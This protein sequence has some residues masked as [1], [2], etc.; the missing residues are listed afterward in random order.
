MKFI[1][2]AFAILAIS[3]LYYC[4]KKEI[5]QPEDSISGAISSNA[6]VPDLPV[7]NFTPDSAR[8]ESGT[9]SKA[10][11]VALTSVAPPRTTPV[12]VAACGSTSWGNSTTKAYYFTYVYDTLDAGA[13]VEG[14]SI[15][16]NLDAVTTPNR[17]SIIDAVTNQLVAASPW[18]GYAIYSGPWGSSVNLRYG[19][20]TFPR[21]TSRYYLVKVETQ[22]KLPGTYNDD[23]LIT[24]GGCTAPT[25]TTRTYAGVTITY[26]SGSGTLK[27]NTGANLATVLDRLDTDYETY[28]T[29]YENQYPS[30]TPDQLDYQ[31]SISNFNE[32]QPIETFEALFPGF[33]SKRKQLVNLETNYLNTATTLSETTDPDSLDL[34]SDVASNAIVNV[35]NKFI[36]GTTTYEY[37]KDGLYADGVKQQA[38]NPSE[39]SSPAALS[40][41]PSFTTFALCNICD[42]CRNW[43]RKSAWSSEYTDDKGRIW[44]F[45][46]VL[47][48]RG[49]YPDGRGYV[50][51]TIKARRKVGTKWKRKRA[52]CWMQM[53]GTIWTNKCIQPTPI[54]S[55]VFQTNRARNNYRKKYAPVGS[56]FFRTKKTKLSA[57]FQIGP[58]GVSNWF[59]ENLTL[60]W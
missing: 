44:R 4:T 60:T 39:L 50:R 46:Q 25:S 40:P 53:A 55:G 1:P 54:N 41:P 43:E 12:K 30:Y 17:F 7:L 42:T 35:N 21:N 11:A 20:L 52:Y 22:G 5:K 57:G 59:A 37:K 8:S 48:I 18:L 6:E 13:V 24:P 31:D 38:E 28:N 15:K 14:T 3:C 10:N 23:F 26:F 2:Y 51:G 19:S 16:L 27:F 56:R 47:A 33:A 58:T 45:K 29:N 9:E 34:S 49:I 36:V 32:W